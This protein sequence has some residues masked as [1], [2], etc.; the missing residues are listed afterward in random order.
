MTINNLESILERA[1]ESSWERFGRRIYFYAPS[2]LYY[3]NEYFKPPRCSFPSVSI[4]GRKCFLNCKHCGG[5]I[6]KS[7]IPA[8]T[9][10]RLIEVLH[11]IKSEGAIGCLISGGCLR[12]GSVPLEEFI[13][14][15]AEAEKIGLKTVVHTGLVSPETA[16]KLRDAGVNSVSIDIIGSD[17]TIREIY[18]LKATVRD[19]EDS[20]RA[21]KEAGINFTPHVLVGLHYGELKG[22]LNALKMISKYNPSALIIIVFFPIKGTVMEKINPPPPRKVAE[23]IVQARF[24]MPNVPIIL[25][26]A[27]PKGKHRAET[28]VLAVKAGV[29]GIAFPEEQ[30]IRTALE[31]GLQI[32]F[33]PTCCSQIY[34]DIIRES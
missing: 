22:E 23:I 20:L 15:I 5:V 19:Y 1:R 34:E 16:E 17:E 28:D 2:F 3:R 21:L 33:S 24:M 7:M 32:S 30:A 6:L 10:R 18:N 8:E 11:R 31:L 4:T 25:G 26:C 14:A 9:P 27:R 13:N 12:N 29:N